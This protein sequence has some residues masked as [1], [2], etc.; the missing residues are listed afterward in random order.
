MI[1]EESFTVRLA[2]HGDAEQI[3][4]LV[5]ALATTQGD[6]DDK[7]TPRRVAR[8]M[9]DPQS[10]M[11]VMVAEN[12]SGRLLGYAAGSPAYESSHAQSGFYVSDL[13]VAERYR[14][15]GIGRALLGAFAAIAHD[16]GRSYLWWAAKPGNTD[17]D[18]FYRRVADIRE[19]VIAYAVTGDRFEVLRTQ[20]QPLAAANGRDEN[21]F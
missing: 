7:A 3:A 11:T 17:A 6:P 1:E 8:D 14:N 5:R 4:V 16:R 9:I 15:Q 18:R 10:G 21:G 2:V 12:P 13:Y 20:A 19:P